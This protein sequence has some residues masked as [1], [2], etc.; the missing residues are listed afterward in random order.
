MTTRQYQELERMWN[1]E[2]KHI[3]LMIRGGT[4]PDDIIDYILALDNWTERE[5][6]KLAM[7][8]GASLGEFSVLKNDKFRRRESP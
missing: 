1:N 5:K 3:Y 2:S 4:N 7:V 8:T 6:L